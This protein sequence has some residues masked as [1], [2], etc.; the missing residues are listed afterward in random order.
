[1]AL[2]PGAQAKNSGGIPGSAISSAPHSEPISKPRWLRLPNM[3]GIQLLPV[4][5]TL[6]W[7]KP[8]APPP[9][10]TKR[11]PDGPAALTPGIP[12][13]SSARLPERSLQSISQTTSPSVS[14]PFYCVTFTLMSHSLWAM[15]L[16]GL[17]P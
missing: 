13:P 2:H 1:M 11:P 14:N 17:Q 16:S 12:G 6:G 15:F 8:P 4:T 5:T 10:A 7:S 9:P 3:P